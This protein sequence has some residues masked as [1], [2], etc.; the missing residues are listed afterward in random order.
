MIRFL[1]AYKH[2]LLQI[3]LSLLLGVFL[4]LLKI[5]T[6]F[7][8]GLH[9][10]IHPD[11]VARDGGNGVRAAIRRPSG[12]DSSSSL[13]GYK[14][15]T[16]NSK[17]EVKRRSKTKDKF[18][19]D[20]NNAQIFR[21]KLDEAHI[22]SRLYFDQYRYCFIYSIVAAFCQLCYY[23]L[24]VGADSGVFVNGSLIPVILGFVGL[25]KLFISLARVSFENSASRR[26]EKQL[27]MLFG[28]L[29]F[30]FGVLILNGIVPG[31]FD[32]DFG[33]IDGFVRVVVSILM[34]CIAGFLYIPAAKS[35]RAFWLGTDQIRSNL[36][37]ISCGWFGRIIVYTNY[38]LIVV[39]AL[40]WINPFI[41]IL[42]IKDRNDPGGAHLIS[43]EV[44][45]QK[46]VGNVGWSQSEFTKLR[47]CCLLVSSFLQ[48]MALRPNVQMY[49]NE[50]L[51]SWYQRLH[52][53]KVPDLEFSRAKVFLHN[54][55]LCMVAL[56]FFALPVLVL[57]F[58]G[59]S[60]IDG[61]SF[62][63]FH[64]MCDFKEVALFMAWWIVFVWAV[65][66]SVTLFLYRRG[67]VYVS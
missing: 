53:S 34:G 26:S 4:T 63:S 39:S 50:A 55:Y 16:S 5:P 33:L 49:L 2:L 11:N 1:L 46:L 9:T 36:G 24:D 32:F 6:V 25:G 28:V 45:A 58:V 3:S 20:E 52:A 56:Q 57:L 47:V 40:L 29:G 65:F 62:K 21:L 23:Y 18:E 61:N 43:S 35:A 12:S 8:L 38:L 19:F 7:L 67:I 13:E 60:Q 14:N 37:M 44:D 51:L 54:H 48:I 31:I 41:K 59:L 64:L 42:V 17:V 15:M 27:S 10:Y 30:L 66:T 22:E